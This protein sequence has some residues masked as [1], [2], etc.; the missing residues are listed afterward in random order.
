MIYESK[1]VEQEISTD[2]DDDDESLAPNLQHEDKDLDE[3]LKTEI[4]KCMCGQDKENEEDTLIDILKTLAGECKSVYTNKNTQV[5]VP[6]CGTNKDLGASVNIIPKSVYEYIKLASLEETSMILE[7][8]DMTEKASFRIVKNIL[9]KIDRLDEYKEEFENE[10]KQLGN[11]YDLRRK[12]YAL[13]D[14]WGKCEE[15][16]EKP[17]PWHDEGFE[18]QKQW[19]SEIEK[20]NYELLFVM[21]DTVEVK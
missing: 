10:I 2:T 15:F 13:D 6:S 20:T 18:E 3:W 14:V 17:Y 11:E 9:V 5:E 8:A 12:K 21:I 7:M 1:T 4:Q 19:E 16:P